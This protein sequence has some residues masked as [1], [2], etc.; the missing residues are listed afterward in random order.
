[1]NKAI[2]WM[3]ITGLEEQDAI[4]QVLGAF[5]SFIISS[6]LEWC[7]LRLRPPTSRN[8]KFAIIKSIDNILF[9]LLLQNTHKH[10]SMWYSFPPIPQKEKQPALQFSKRQASKV[11]F[12]TI[13][14][15]RYPS[16][17]LI[18]EPKTAGTKL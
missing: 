10:N 3:M 17:T 8:D 6:C 15:V 12:N 2:W 9:L 7:M 4:S 13:D 16:V 1:M 18:M 14:S 11:L 5:N